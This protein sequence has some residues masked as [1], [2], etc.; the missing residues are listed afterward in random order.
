[1]RKHYHLNQV[2]Y[3]DMDGLKKI[4]DVYGHEAGDRAILAE[5]IILRSNFRSNDIIA[6]IGGD[7]FAILSPGLTKDALKHIR[8]Q[9]E[10]DCRIWS[11]GNEA[12]FS[13][14]ISMGCVQYPSKKM[15]YKITPLLSE[16]DSLMYME[17]RSKKTKKR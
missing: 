11:E 17:K 15:G 4:N 12:G 2:I 8:E 9:I 3:C 14:S 13:I 7:E 5:S 16:A 10:A 1:M 6:R